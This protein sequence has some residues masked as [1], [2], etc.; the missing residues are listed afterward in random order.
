[1]KQQAIPAR[2]QIGA[3]LAALL[4]YFGSST[5]SQA[6]GNSDQVAIESIVVS[7]DTAWAKGDA[8]A[9]AEHFA[10]DGGFTNV[11]GKVYF[12][13]EAFRTR[14]DAIFKTVFKGSTS[15]LA[16]AKLRF[17]RPDVAI[18]D[19]DAEIRGFAALPPGMQAG[20]DG[21]GRSKLLLV[22]V[23]DGG[24][25]WITAYHNVGVAALPPKL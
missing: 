5:M 6:Q 19:V 14:H 9:F 3:V 10:P 17:V 8:D 12:G 2:F 18:A 24:E 22:L 7:L 25:W 16:I 21:V 13:R 23:R 1:M 20:P 4:V 11:L 15:K